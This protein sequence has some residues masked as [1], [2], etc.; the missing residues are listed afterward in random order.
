MSN[1]LHLLCFPVYCTAFCFFGFYCLNCRPLLLA[2][3]T[4]MWPSDRSR[5]SWTGRER[6][7]QCKKTHTSTPVNTEPIKESDTLFVEEHTLTVYTQSWIIKTVTV[8]AVCVG[9]GVL[10]DAYLNRWCKSTT[11]HTH[12]YT[13][14]RFYIKHHECVRRE[15]IGLVSL[16]LH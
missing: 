6:V 12:I 7:T 1:S 2:V 5:M 10:L 8:R 3:G 4:I 9:K 15:G 14:T 16:P 13:H 11:T